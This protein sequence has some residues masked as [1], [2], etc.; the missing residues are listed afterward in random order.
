MLGELA[1]RWW[2]EV[3][4]DTKRAGYE[5]FEDYDANIK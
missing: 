2:N 1:H 5:L 3:I 4:I